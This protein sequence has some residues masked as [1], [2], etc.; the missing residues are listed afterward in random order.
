MS[1]LEK[2][3]ARIIKEA[4]ASASEIKKK[5]E[6]KAKDILEQAKQEAQNK[7]EKMLE[8][9]EIEATEVYRR[10][11]SVHKLE[12]RKKILKAKQSLVD[13]AFADAMH[14]LVNLPKA[15]YEELMLGLI[16]KVVET[17]EEEI[18]LCERDAQSFKDDFV[19]KINNA[20][21]KNGKKS[22]VKISSKTVHAMGGFILSAGDV[23]LNYT[24]ETLFKKGRDELEA[25]VYNHL[26]QGLESAS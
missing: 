5:A 23:Q 2:I 11:L 19:Q 12:A 22:N 26:F 21:S 20:I 14:H 10:I 25:E 4:E 3:K 16:T 6:A 9:A 8:K 18:L 1:G 24:F 15:E 7:Q 17:G 13:K